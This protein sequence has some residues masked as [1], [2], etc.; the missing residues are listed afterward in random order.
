[1]KKIAKIFSIIIGLSVIASCDLDLLDNPNAVTTKNLDVNYLLNSIEL[2]FA[3]SFNGFQGT[4][5]ALTRIYHYG[6]SVNYDNAVGPGTLAGLW[7]N[8]YAN[9]LVDI[10]ALIPVAEASGLF[11]H[12]GIAKTL[13]AYTLLTMVDFLGDVPLSEALNP[14][15]FNPK[16]DDGKTVYTAAIADLDAAIADFAKTSKGGATSDLIYGGNADSWTRAANSIKL[17][18]LLNLKLTDKAGTTSGIN[19]LISGNKLISTTAQNFTFKY[20]SN[21]TNPD[22]RHPRYQYS[23]TGIGDYMSNSFMGELYSSKSKPD[24]RIRYYYY[25]Q[26]V[27]NTKDVN[28]LRC[29]TNNKPAHY[30]ANDVFCLPGTVGYW[31]R[32]HLSNE[33]TPPDGLRKTGYGLYPSGGLFDDDAAKPVLLGVGAGGAGIAPF[34]MRSFVDFMLAESALTLGTTGDPKALLKS[35]IE[36]SMADVRAFAMGTSEASKINAFEAAKGI[37]WANEVTSYVNEVLASYDAAPTNDARLA[38][39][40]KEY[41][42]SLYG[43]GVEAYNLYRR[44]GQP[45]QQPAL[46]PN[47][48]TFAYSIYYPTNYI[49][50]NKN[51]KQKANPGVKVF[52]DTNTFT[53]K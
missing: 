11:V 47:P 18:A 4:G 42:L 53:L 6:G 9:T 43:S 12:S 30:T 46:D 38:I 5:A 3:G 45:A 48:G 39:I 25:R 50:Q 17:K 51:A 41:W 37:V 49:A 52:W 36:K 23:N 22:T 1:M 24:P 27:V 28:E 20:G 19:T 16:A 40:A 33:G 31:G 21:L 34:L 15:N 44:T 10:K 32:D 35:A 26:T 14:E 2:T 7:N 13:R 29:I 8:V